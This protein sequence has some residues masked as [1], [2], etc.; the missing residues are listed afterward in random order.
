MTGP[1][2]ARNLTSAGHAAASGWTQRSREDAIA[3]NA[4]KLVQLGLLK[5]SK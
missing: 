1:G 2:K 5:K 3:S 4:E